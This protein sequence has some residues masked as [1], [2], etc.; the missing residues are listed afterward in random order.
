[1]CKVQKRG[2]G[3]KRV[4]GKHVKGEPC[5]GETCKVG[6][7][8]KGEMGMGDTLKCPHAKHARVALVGRASEVL[9]CARAFKR[10]RIHARAFKRRRIQDFHRLH[11][12][13][14]RSLRSLAN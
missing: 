2:K 13:V 5:K 1:M 6:K 14:A 9:E 7:R 10:R 8:V 3:G 4:K 11:L 12:R